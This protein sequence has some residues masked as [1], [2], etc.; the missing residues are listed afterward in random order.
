MLRYG[1]IIFMIT[2]AA[3]VGVFLYVSTGLVR[4]LSVQERQRMEIWA[5]ATRGIVSAFDS[6]NPADIDFLLRIIQSNTNIPVLLT[7]DDGNILQFRNFN[8]PDPAGADPAGPLSATNARY[9]QSKLENLSHSQNVIH[10][11]IAPALPSTCT[12][13]TQPCSSACSSIRMW[14]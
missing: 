9:L 6:D 11:S 2:A 8:L 14:S 12:T 10:I 5:D 7:D 3:V 4:D 13:K 1:K